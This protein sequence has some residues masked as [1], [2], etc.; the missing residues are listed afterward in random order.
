VAG[1]DISVCFFREFALQAP[2]NV[3][4]SFDRVATIATI[5]SSIMYL[6]KKVKHLS[7]IGTTSAL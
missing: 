6:V 4:G 1:G 5:L 2:D 3:Q 7:N